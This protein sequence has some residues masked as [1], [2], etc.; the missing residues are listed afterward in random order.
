VIDRPG[1]EPFVKDID[2]PQ[3]TETDFWRRIVP[4]DVVL[5]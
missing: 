2:I 3:M 5:P 4:I 1:A